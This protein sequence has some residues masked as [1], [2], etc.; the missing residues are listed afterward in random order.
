MPQRASA[1][2][3]CCSR[4]HFNQA[5]SCFK[6]HRE[7]LAVSQM[8]TSRRSNSYTIQHQ[9]AMSTASTCLLFTCQSGFLRMHEERRTSHPPE[10]GCQRLPDFLDA[11]RR[12]YRSSQASAGR[13]TMLNFTNLA[14][15]A[16]RTPK[17][18]RISPEIRYHCNTN[19]TPRMHLA[20]H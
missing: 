12:K 2:G 20:M 16:P 10:A 1:G 14:Q 8:G 9:E 18:K 13:L 4:N 6:R 7:T 3:A 11:P 15:M 19:T 5:T 17:V